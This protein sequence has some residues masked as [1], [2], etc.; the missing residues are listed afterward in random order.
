MAL[1]R[2]FGQT[3]VEQVNRVPAFAQALLDEAATQFLI[4]EPGSARRI[5]RYR[6][7]ATIG[8][9]K[10]AAMTDQPSKSLHRLLS[11]AGNPSMDNLAASFLDMRE[12][13]NAGFEAHSIAA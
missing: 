1:T 7:N 2:K 12:C 10:S 3:V 13:L 4:G 11:T 6:V 9:G 5:L 8:F